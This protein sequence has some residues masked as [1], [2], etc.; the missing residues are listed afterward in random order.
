MRV[1][2]LN[3]YEDITVHNVS[4]EVFIP[5]YPN[6]TKY[7]I[8]LRI[9]NTP[10]KFEIP[11]SDYDIGLYWNKK[12]WLPKPID[13]DGGPVSVRWGIVTPYDFIKFDQTT[14]S[15][16]FNPIDVSMIGYYNIMVTLTDL[17]MGTYSEE[18]TLTVHRPPILSAKMKKNYLVKVG[19]VVE[20]D[21]SLYSTDGID[22]SHASLPGFVTFDKFLYT[23]KPTIL[24]HLGI[25]P[26]KGRL[27][28]K[29]GFLDFDF[30][31]EVTNDPP[32]LAVNPKD[33]VI[34]QDDKVTYALPAAIDPED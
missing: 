13:P 29:W 3:F 20:L 4:L 25:F 12:Y 18:F 34:L 30:R 6:T 26:I 22:T 21:L 8:N 11:L 14:N 24:S 15:F 1:Y 7:W 28:N 17:H 33:L 16:T 10:P 32:I 9:V 27:Q 23:I 19:S 2:A 31:I 5:N